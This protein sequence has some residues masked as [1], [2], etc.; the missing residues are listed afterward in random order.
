MSLRCM[1]PGC[2]E[3]KDSGFCFCQKHN[4]IVKLETILELRKI[5]EISRHDDYRKV[6]QTGS[7]ILQ[8]NSTV[9]AVEEIKAALGSV[10]TNPYKSIR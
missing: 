3:H 4:V 5:I 7:R 2:A 6:I 8:R 9:K 1:Y 10:R